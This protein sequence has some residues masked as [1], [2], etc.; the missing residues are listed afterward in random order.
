MKGYFRFLLMRHVLKLVID[1]LSKLVEQ[2]A[3]AAI[4][5]VA[6]RLIE[7]SNKPHKTPIEEVVLEVAEPVAKMVG[8]AL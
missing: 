6:D 4:D 5:W 7:L 3:V 8:E 1:Y 2:L